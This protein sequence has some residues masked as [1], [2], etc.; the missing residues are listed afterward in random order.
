MF[1]L[2]LTPGVR[3]FI[4]CVDVGYVGP[5]PASPKR[6][7]TRF[8]HSP[9]GPEHWT[10]CSGFGKCCLGIS[11]AINFMTF[12]LSVASA[13]TSWITA[14]FFTLLGRK[15]IEAQA[16]PAFAFRLQTIIH[17]IMSARIVFHVVETT[18]KDITRAE[19]SLI[20][21]QCCLTTH[22][23]MEEVEISP[24]GQSVARETWA[25]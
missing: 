19:S 8:K 3:Y 7:L 22:I 23:E 18:S 12:C 10:H 20:M 6:V 1:V 9:R 13:P 4:F 25:T 15:A 2:R 11:D 16:I 5:T 14:S 21:T 17:S 24:P